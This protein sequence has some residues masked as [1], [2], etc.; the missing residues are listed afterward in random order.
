MLQHTSGAQGLKVRIWVV[1][2][3]GVV[4]DQQR[5]DVVENEPK[6]VCVLNCVQ[7]G[8]V[9]C[10]EGRSQAAHTGG[11]QDFTHLGGTKKKKCYL[12]SVVYEQF[13]HKAMKV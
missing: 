5:L 3:V 4:V 2:Q 6:L 7:A 1:Q 10:Q 13:T 11:V 8:M 9:L 12:G